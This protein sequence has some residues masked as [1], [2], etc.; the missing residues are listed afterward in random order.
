M[1]AG[2]SKMMLDVPAS[3]LAGQLPQ[4]IRTV[5]GFRVWH[6]IFCRSCRRLRS[7]D[8]AS[9]N[10][11]IAA[12]LHSAAPARDRIRHRFHGGHKPVGD[13]E[14]RNCVRRKPKLWELACQR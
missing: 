2:Q 1:A 12:S 3:S 7:F 5:H 13:G 10:L 8:L 14:H 11:K 4:R 6:R 9:E